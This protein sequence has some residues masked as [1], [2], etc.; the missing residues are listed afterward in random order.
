MGKIET[1]L[2][3]G[4]NS[5]VVYPTPSSWQNRNVTF[6]HSQRYRY[7]RLSTQQRATGLLHIQPNHTIR[8]DTIR[9]LLFTTP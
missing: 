9:Q 4:G 8:Q 2:I 6:L 1:R 5:L 7:P 3:H